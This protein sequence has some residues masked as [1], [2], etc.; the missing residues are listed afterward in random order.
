MILF[1]SFIYS[2]EDLTKSSEFLKSYTPPNFAFKYWRLSPNI[3]KSGSKTEDFERSQFNIGVNN[4]FLFYQQA[5]KMNTRLSVNTNN[6]YRKG[7]ANDVA[8]GNDNFV[9]IN[10]F[11]DFQND[12]YFREKLFLGTGLIQN[13]FFVREI[14]DDWESSSENNLFLDLGIGFGRPY[15]VTG[16]WRAQTFFN[17]LECNGLAVDHSYLTELSD[18]LTLQRNRRIMDSRLLRIQNQTDLYN[19]LID[20]NITEFSPL[21][22]SVINDSYRFE[23][24]TTR[25]RGLRLFGGLRPGV[26]SE[27][28]R[29]ESSRENENR[30]YLSPIIELAYYLPISEDWQLN[31]QTVGVYKSL[32]NQDD[33]S[34]YEIGSSVSLSWLPNQRIRSTTSLNY[35]G[36]W[37]DD[38]KFRSV[39]LSYALEYYFSPRFVGSFSATVE[40]VWSQFFALDPNKDLSHRI[41]GGFNY[42]IF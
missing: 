30:Y 2:Q 40:Q 25:R 4:N 15:D 17:D 33:F 22:V 32:V 16:A 21:S 11:V 26:I 28:M 5:D 12:L 18:L 20:N 42:F 19:F 14:I 13:G 9:S 29:T 37:Q 34:N 24:F 31:T 36:R 41:A 8:N 7:K 39:G 27:G 35:L 23:T 6:N 3:R 38:F 10:G 1:S